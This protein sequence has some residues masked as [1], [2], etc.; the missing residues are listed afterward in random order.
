MDEIVDGVFHW[1]RFHEGIERTVHST[2][3]AA[4]DP[5]VLIDPMPPDV[6]LDWF[7]ARQPRH[8]YLTNRHHYRGSDRFV[9]AF[10]CNVHCHEAGLHEFEDG[11]DVRSYRHGDELPGGVRIL[12]VGSLCPEECALHVPVGKGVLALGDAVVRFDAEL[13]FVPD[14][15]MGDDPEAVKAGIR[16]ALQRLLGSDLRFDTL[17]LA[18]GEP[19][20]GGGRE[21]LE[22]FAAGG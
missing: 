12:E 20:V 11:R 6:E 3:V 2:F 7:D 5:P 13:G 15:L 22:D 8:V 14:F 21:A 4:T 9:E 18:H 17:V 1:S 16:S 10:G 19:L